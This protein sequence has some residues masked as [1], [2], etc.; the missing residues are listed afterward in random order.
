METKQKTNIHTWLQTVASI[1]AI[2]GFFGVVYW[3]NLLPNGLMRGQEPTP[4]SSSSNYPTPI[5]ANSIPREVVRQLMYGE[6]SVDQVNGCLREAHRDRRSFVSIEV[7]DSVPG[8]ALVAT[9]LSRDG[10]VWSAFPV[11]PICHN[12]SWG[13]FESSNSYI[14]PYEG[15]YWLILD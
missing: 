9:D 4:T 12:G 15:A 7:G 13:L 1:I 6:V 8:K 5:P 10:R 11:I 2:L 3:T 14:A